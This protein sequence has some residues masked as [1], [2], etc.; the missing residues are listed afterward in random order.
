MAKRGAFMKV[1]ALAMVCGAAALA[2]CST[3]GSRVNRGDPIRALL[4][5]DAM[6]FTAFDA[7]ANFQV[8][9]TE[10]E[11]GIARELS[12]ADANG[13]GSVGPIEFQNWSNVVLG[14]GMTPPYRL[15]FDRN[16]DNVIS[17]EEFRTEILARAGEYDADE[18]GAIS[19]AEFVRSL[20]QAR[21]ARPAQALQQPGRTPTR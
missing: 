16:V 5:A 9:M 1:W 3:G 6:M 12:R 17:A 19:R 11:A 14:G 7:D 8:T 4:S 18:S 10:V 15:D 2:A 20:N 21:P 13:D